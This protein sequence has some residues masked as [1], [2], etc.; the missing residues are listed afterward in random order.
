VPTDRGANA[1][2]KIA[3]LVAGMVLVAGSI[4]DMQ[5]L[6]NGGR[7]RLFGMICAPSTLGSFLREFRFGHCAAAGCRRR[8][9]DGQCRPAWRL[10]WVRI[11]ALC[12]CR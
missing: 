9:G 8:S 4:D 6:R 3:S 2:T 7:G 10:Y 1:G 5:L 12:A 11:R